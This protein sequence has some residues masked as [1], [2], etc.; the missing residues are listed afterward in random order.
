MQEDEI[1]LPEEIWLKILSHLSK[2]DIY[3]VSFVSK[4]LSTLTRNKGRHLYHTAPDPWPARDYQQLREKC[5]L[6]GCGEGSYNVFKNGD[7]IFIEKSTEKLFHLRLDQHQWKAVPVL[8]VQHV[9]M[10]QGNQLCI[11]HRQGITL[12]HTQTHFLTH[13]VQKMQLKQIG[14]NAAGKILY[15][16]HDGLFIIDLNNPQHHKEI[17][18]DP[19]AKVLKFDFQKEK[20][21]VEL[22]NAIAFLSDEGFYLKTISKKQICQTIRKSEIKKILR[23]L[24]HAY[25]SHD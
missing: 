16:T 19:P 2:R 3:S 5:F 13:L 14:V 22:E 8:G 23:P 18:S 12:W 25:Q 9:L 10:L 17:I 4:T 6:P 11:Q 21:I 1:Y 24:A 7:T 15:H 20:T